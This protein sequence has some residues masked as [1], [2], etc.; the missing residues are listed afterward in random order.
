MTPLR[1]WWINHYACPAD[2]PGGTRHHALARHLSRNGIDA[3]IIASN[4]HYTQM[5]DRLA[6]D[7]ST[8]VEDRDGVRYAWIRSR[9]YSTSRVAKLRSMTSFASHLLR[10]A[11]TLPL[12]RPDVIVGSSP[13]LYAADAARRI[14][15]RFDVPFCCEIRDLWPS[16]LVDV[17]G[18]SRWNPIVL[19]MAH[20]ERRVYRS[21]ERIFTL[22]PDSQEHICN[23]GGR[24][25]SVDWIPNG[26]DPDLLPPPAS[27]AEQGP[28]TV[29]YAGAHGIANGLD[30]VLDA[31]K[32]LQ[33]EYGPEDLRL[34]L[35]G[36]GPL[37]RTLMRRV[38]DEG[39]QLVEFHEPVS[40]TEIHGLIQRADA[41][42]M[43]LKRGS[44][45]R[46]GVSPNKMFDY[47]AAARPVIFSVDSTRDP[48]QAAGA[49]ISIAPED[50][51]ALAEAVV[52]LASMEPE[53]RS[54]MGRRGRDW[55]LDHHDLSKLAG[56]VAEALREVTG[57]S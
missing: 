7:E 42:L 15:R 49:G 2:E 14:A 56:L 57:R 29:V 48:V 24:S 16:S 22:L 44:V 4:F 39:I 35:V 9:P 55:V 33:A 18:A 13:H 20:I 47:L 36:D 43:P 40:K 46:H 27:P 34:L 19:H 5:R 8:R 1:C 17:A 21:A 53:E 37:K 28:F 25:G 10:V 52:S 30:A 12:E 50:P 38:A 11:D 54:E 6:P 26:V 31:A 51:V 41:C 45:F 23:R 3:S 32:L